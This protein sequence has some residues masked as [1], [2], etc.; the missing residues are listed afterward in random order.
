MTWRE[1]LTA[2]GDKLKKSGIAEYEIDAWYLFSE[3]FGISRAEFFL[4]RDRESG[5]SV[6][7][8]C[9]NE[10]ECEAASS[11]K[12]EKEASA[13][14]KQLQE[15][16]SQTDQSRETQFFRFRK[17]ICLRSRRI[18]L[19]QITGHQEFMGLDF[20]VNEH[21]LCPRQ[22]TE[23]LVETVLS[24]LAEINVSRGTEASTAENKIW[25]QSGERALKPVERSARVV[26]ILDMCA[27]S[28]CI[29]ISL[30]RL[31]A[32]PVNVLA[33]DISD[34][35]IKVAESNAKRLSCEHYEIVKS[36]LFEQISGS[37]DVIV[38]NPPYI[39]S[40]VIET[41]EDEV[42]LHEPRIA[43]D[44]EA[45]GLTF[46]R[47]ISEAAVDHLNLGGRIYYEIGYD[48]G[49]AVS[50]ILSEN[51]FIDIRVIRDLAGLD[52]VVAA[53]LPG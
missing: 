6:S 4:C 21:V 41:L 10:N 47:K 3:A 38:S 42:R 19:Q 30:E 8:V 53:R 52:R 15:G 16:Q 17:M 29:G 40:A 50:D 51:G 25:M 34:G 5:I 28:G 11:L 18:P 37:F 23:V 9:R 35:A 48:Q 24:E 49:R 12:T 45:D 27:G 44:G 7:D 14:I 31:S 2:A 32:T 22:D 43:L 26:R 1:L 36:N 20:L 13:Q 39:P 33:A 46:Y